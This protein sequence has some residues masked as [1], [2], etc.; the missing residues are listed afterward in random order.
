MK[1]YR[2]P[3]GMLGTNCYIVVDEQSNQ[4][5]VVDPGSDGEHVVEV[6]Q[7]KK[8]NPLGVVLTHGHSDHIG[9]IQPIVDTYHCPIYVH[10]KDESFLTDSR[11][12]LSVYSGSTVEAHG[13]VRHVKE[14]DTL[15]CGSLSFRVIET[16]GHTPGGVCY[17]GEGILLAGDTLFRESVGRTDF[18]G[19]SFDDLVAA[20]SEK[21]FSL[22]EETVVYPGHGPET[23]IAHEKE[24]NPFVR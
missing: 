23:T 3:L 7:E 9:G 22:P 10:K 11:L 15:S 6:L 17:Y 20:V 4:C 18:P 14:G 21:L 2:M 24:Y 12:N 8:L 16:P 13:E 1:L 5:L 19:G